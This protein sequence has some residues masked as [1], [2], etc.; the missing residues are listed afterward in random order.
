MNK[1]NIIVGVVVVIIGILFFRNIFDNNEAD[2]SK[3]AGAEFLERTAAPKAFRQRHQDCSIWF[4]TPEP[5]PNIRG[6][7]TRSRFII[8]AP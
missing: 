8:M 1:F 2:M 7:L 4:S 5:E 6:Q 3:Q